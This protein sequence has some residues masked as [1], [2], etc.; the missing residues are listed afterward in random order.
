MNILKDNRV[1]EYI[2]SLNGWNPIQ[3]MPLHCQCFGENLSEDAHLVIAY[4]FSNNLA[5][6]A[7]IQGPKNVRSIIMYITKTSYFNGDTMKYLVNEMLQ[8]KDVVTIEQ[9]YN[10]LDQNLKMHPPCAQYMDKEY[11]KLLLVSYRKYFGEMSLWDYII[12]LL[13]QITT[14]D[15]LYGDNEAYDLAFKRCLSFCICILKIDFEVSKRKNV[16]SLVAKC[17][18]YHSARRTRMSDITKLL[19]MLYNTG[20]NFQTQVIDLALLVNQ[21]K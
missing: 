7:A 16:R 18:N 15:I 8:C 5:E 3:C 11:E 19:D 21:L 20:Y 9:Y 6:L 1:K 13:N 14:G 17:L 10:V 12:E 4:P 2:S